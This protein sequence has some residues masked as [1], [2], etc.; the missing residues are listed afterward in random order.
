M[1]GR[2][3]PVIGDQWSVK[4]R[5]KVEKIEYPISSTECPISKC[6]NQEKRV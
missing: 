4:R 3:K 2:C 1:E 6:K 5:G